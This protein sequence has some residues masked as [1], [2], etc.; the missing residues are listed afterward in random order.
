MKLLIISLHVT[1]CFN[2]SIHS[3]GGG[4]HLLIKSARLFLISSKSTTLIV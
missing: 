2:A 3:Y 1:H 4:A